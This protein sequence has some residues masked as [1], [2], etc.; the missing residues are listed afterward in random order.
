MRDC[1]G[2]LDGGWGDG[3]RADW[4]GPR[5]ARLFGGD[6]DFVLSGLGEREQVLRALVDK[7]VSI[8]VKGAD[9][10]LDLV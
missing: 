4:L 3:S 7:G 5:H 6:G 9:V 10:R 1:L 2:D 8:C